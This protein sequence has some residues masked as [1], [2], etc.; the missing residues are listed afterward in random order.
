[1]ETIASQDR[2]P[3]RKMGRGTQVLAACAPAPTSA[4]RRVFGWRTLGLARYGAGPY[5]RCR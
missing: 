2:I 5:L 3:R 1:M 4:A